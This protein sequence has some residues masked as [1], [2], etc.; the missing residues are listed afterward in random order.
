M[1][2][3]DWSSDVCSSDLH[4]PERSRRF[5]AL[6]S[7]I[8]ADVLHVHGLAFAG[9]AFA[10]SRRLPRMPI[11][12]QD[13]ADRPPRWWRRR[14]WK[15]W[16]EAVSGVSFTAAEQAQRFIDAG[17]FAKDMQVF[18]IPESSSRFTPG[19]RERARSGT[20]LHGDPCVLWVGHLN[21][22]KDPLTVIDGVARAAL[23][24]PDLQLWC[25][26]GTAPLLREVQ[27]LIRARPQ[28]AG[29]VTLLGKVQHAHGSALMRAPDLVVF[30]CRPQACCAPPF[31]AT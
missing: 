14:P 26:F 8:G 19:D 18:A 31:S 22:G 30:V 2:I 17:V 7:G 13:H 3:S 23:Q 21:R 15:R 5:A 24:L 10:V 25:V 1:R 27:D 6:L 11:L 16:Y 12:C 28:L 9:D 29:R 20:G 4:A